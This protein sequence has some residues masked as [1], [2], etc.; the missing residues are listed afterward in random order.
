[1]QCAVCIHGGRPACRPCRPA[2]GRR[3]SGSGQSS[4]FHV[5][6]SRVHVLESLFHM[7]MHIYIYIMHVCTHPTTT[8]CIYELVLSII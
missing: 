1:M 6:A 4:P 5:L 2:G 3:G 7:H 8:V